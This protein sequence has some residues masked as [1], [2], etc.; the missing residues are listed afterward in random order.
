MP[1]SLKLNNKNW[2]T[3]KNEVWKHWLLDTYFFL[4]LILLTIFF[5]LALNAQPKA[6]LRQDP[7]PTDMAFA[8]F[9]SSLTFFHDY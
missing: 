9:V 2:K 5:V 6:E 4:I 8:V 1:K 7:V 3:K